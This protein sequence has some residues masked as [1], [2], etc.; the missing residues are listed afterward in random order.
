MAEENQHHHRESEALSGE[1]KDRGM[2]DFMGKKKKEEEKKK[3]EEEVLVSEFE[4]VKVEEVEGEERKKKHGLL[5]K[6]HRSDSSSSSS[7]DEEEGDQGEAKEK[8]K[9]KKGLKEKIKEK[10]SSGKDKE[11]E[12]EE[13]DDDDDKEVEVVHVDFTS[14]AA[15]T[16]SHDSTTVEVLKSEESLVETS[17]I[18]ISPGEEKKGFLEKIKEKLPGGHKKVEEVPIEDGEGVGQDKKGFLEKIKEKFPGYH[19]NGGDHD[20]NDNN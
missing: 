2:F 1:V 15:V 14:S 8:K 9:K 4:E 3:F 13:E 20:H 17:T 11:K 10:I 5:E 16:A 19:K 12:E 7:S 18:V 6:L